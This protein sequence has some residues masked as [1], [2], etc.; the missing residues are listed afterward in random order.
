MQTW[1]RHI[2]EAIRSFLNPKS[3]AIITLSPPPMRQGMLPKLRD[4]G[5]TGPRHEFVWTQ[6]QVDDFRISRQEGAPKLRRD[7]AGH[8]IVAEARRVGP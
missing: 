7:E 3:Q 5:K 8:L 2:A 6:E 1:V 4:D